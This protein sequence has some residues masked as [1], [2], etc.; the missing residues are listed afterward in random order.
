M[1]KILSEGVLIVLLWILTFLL[2]DAQKYCKKLETCRGYGDL[3]YMSLEKPQFDNMKGINCDFT[4]C[5][6]FKE[7]CGLV[8][9][10]YIESGAQIV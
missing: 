2:V 4:S 10:S 6:G 8:R 5:F 3:C 9:F 7:F 1:L